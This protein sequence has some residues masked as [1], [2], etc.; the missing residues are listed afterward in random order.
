MGFENI[1]THLLGFD[2]E[3]TDSMS[4]LQGHEAILKGS[5]IGLDLH[6]AKGGAMFQHFLFIKCLF[7][8]NG[9]ERMRHDAYFIIHLI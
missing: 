6:H 5:A 4:K 9:K 7:H 3:G 8:K 2:W 1:N